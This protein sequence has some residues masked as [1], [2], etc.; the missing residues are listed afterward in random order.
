MLGRWQPPVLS[1]V[2]PAA[3]V[4]AVPAAL[5]RSEVP[6]RELDDRLRARFGAQAVALTDSGTSALVLAFRIAVPPRGTVALPA[7]ACVDLLAAAAYAG[8]RVRFYDVDPATLSPDLASVRGALGRGADAIVVAHLYGY[9]ADVPGVAALAAE[10]GAIVIEDAAQHAAGSL[11]GSPL[12]SLG[13]LVILSFGRGKGTTGGNG[14]ALLA[15][16]ATW[17]A[18]VAERNPKVGTAGWRDWVLATAQWAIG[19]P[20]LYAI[21]ASIPALKLGETIYKEAHEPARL[22]Y[23]AAVLASSALAGADAERA[24]RVQRARDLIDALSGTP[25]LDIVR[26]MEGGASGYLRLP[27]LD[28]AQRTS[29]PRFGVV[30]SYPRPLVEEDAAQKLMAEKEPSVAIGA[31]MVCRELFTLPTHGRVAGLDREHLVQWARD[32]RSG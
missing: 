24:R 4:R 9:P 12:G 1:P 19:R 20:G 2:A 14:G 26:P 11:D 7:Y 30:R 29:A 16:D 6:V 21:P 13:P 8:L 22:S 18:S 17:A 25:A 23:A 15:R 32:I 5:A 28:K 27:I 10:H 31:Q 3:L